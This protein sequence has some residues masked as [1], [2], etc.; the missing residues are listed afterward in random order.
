[1]GKALC[2][3]CGQPIDIRAVEVE[4]PAGP[5]TRWIPYDMDIFKHRHDCQSSRANSQL[6]ARMATPEELE[7]MRAGI[8]ARK[9][10][11]WR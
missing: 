1:M 3:G 2:S 8:S 11:R 5:E 7:K 10:A 9:Q 4:G 6:V